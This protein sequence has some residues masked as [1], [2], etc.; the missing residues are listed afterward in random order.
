MEALIVI[1]K[2][3]NLFAHNAHNKTKGMTFFQDHDFFGSAYEAYDSAYDSLV[4][5]CIGLGKNPNLVQIAKS[6]AGLVEKFSENH[7]YESL[8]DLE[9]QIC[10]HI[11]SI[12]EQHTEGTKNLLAQLADDSEVRQYKIQQRLKGV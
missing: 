10:K 7:S 5:R 2:A 12:M 6:A 1:F 9:K 3:L 4:E 11:E 8:L